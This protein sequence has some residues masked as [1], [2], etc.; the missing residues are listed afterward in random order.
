VFC[1]GYC[2][3]IPP[4]SPGGCLCLVFFF[5][6]LFDTGPVC[7]NLHRHSFSYYSFMRFFPATRPCFEWCS[8]IVMRRILQ[9]NVLVLTLYFGNILLWSARLGEGSAGMSAGAGLS[10]GAVFPHEGSPQLDEFF[11]HLFQVVTPASHA[12]VSVK[13]NFDISRRFLLLLSFFQASVG[14]PFFF[15]PLRR[16]QVADFLP[17]PRVRARFVGVVPVL[18]WCI[19]LCSLVL[20]AVC[21]PLSF[22]TTVCGLIERRPYGACGEGPRAFP[23]RARA[24][25]MS[26]RPRSSV[27]VRVRVGV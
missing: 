24:H 16:F 21:V 9:P 23:P 1:R 22:S 11:P 13:H 4:L 25:R 8:L 14:C 19:A 3:Y 20:G 27:A 10:L 2:R 18:I 15:S 5:V 26:R 7:L 17:F 12:R 6:S